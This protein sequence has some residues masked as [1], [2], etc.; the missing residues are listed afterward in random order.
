MK[1]LPHALRQFIAD[2]SGV[3]LVEF[4]IVLPMMLLTFAVTIEGARLM[5]AY[6]SAISGVRD[7]TRYLSRI[8]PA[9]ICTTGGSATTYTSQLTT[10]VGQSVGGQ[11]VFPSAV[12]LNSVTPS[13][14][15]VTGT[16][17]VNPAP[18]A[19][20]SASVTITYPFSGI[21]TL[22]GGTVPSVTTT[23]TD[24]SRIFGS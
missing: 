5:L 15:C 8:L 22:M 7:A 16:Y 6:Q 13:Y 2:E 24:R 17:R 9:T 19:T 20:V 18:V 4:A 23:V 3:A 12:T 11:S 10:I 21:F 1:Y 14:A